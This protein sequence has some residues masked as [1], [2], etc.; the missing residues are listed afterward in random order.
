MD[1]A[2]PGCQFQ[3]TPGQVDRMI[4]ALESPRQS[5]LISQGCEIPCQEPI[6]LNII[7][8]TGPLLFGNQYLIKN[9]TQ[10]AVSYI[11]SWYNGPSSSVDL[12]FPSDNIGVFEICIT[13]TGSSTGCHKTECHLIDVVCSLVEPIFQMSSVKINLGETLQLNQTSITEPGYTYT[14]F[15]NGVQISNGSSIAFNPSQEGNIHISVWDL[16]P[17]DVRQIIG[18]LHEIVYI[19]IGIQEHP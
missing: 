19:S 13:A 15:I 2:P 16:V 18:S 3:F 7:W 1:Y 12:N 11:W 10:G 14:W 5:L 4:Q 8:P 17:Q 9:S 6:T